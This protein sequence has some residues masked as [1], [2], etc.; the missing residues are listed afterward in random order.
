MKLAIIT[1]THFGTRGDSQIFLKNQ[2]KFYEEIFFPYLDDHDIKTVLHLGDTFDRRKYIN[3][4][5]L[6]ETKRFFFDEISKRSIDYHMIT[7]NHD[8]FFT[9]INDVNSIDLLLREYENFNIYQDDSVDLQFG[10]TKITMVPWI[11]RTNSDRILEKISKCN[12]HILAGHFQIKG[13]EMNKGSVATHGLDKDIFKSFEA[14]YSGHFHHPSEYNNIKYLGAP[15]EMTWIDHAGKRGFHILDCKT[16]SLKHI[17]NPHRIF[18]KIEYDDTDM[19]IEDV[20]N[21]DTSM[22]KD[23]YIKLIVKN[24]TN[25]YLHE[26]FMDKLVDS[27]ATDVKSIEDSLNLESSGIEDILDESKDTKEILHDYIN[28]IETTIDKQKIKNEID[29]LYTEAFS[30]K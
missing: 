1:D 10:G 26:L 28:S 12:S 6:R 3:F 29:G 11:N 2:E 7:G 23:T 21:L 30:L 16:R 19:T 14:V 18:F 15:Y 27:G 13:F 17:Q 22:L 4:V 24:K 20:A 5:T 25:P 9:N 8:T